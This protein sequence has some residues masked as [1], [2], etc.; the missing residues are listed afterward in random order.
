MKTNTSLLGGFGLALVGTTCCALPILLV[1][2]G[3]GSAVASLVSTLPWLVTL[4]KYK[5]VTFT[6]TALILAYSFLRLRN[7]DSCEIVDQRRLKRQRALLWASTVIVIVSVFT[8]YAL[9][10]FTLWLESTL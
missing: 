6:I 7:M 5:A 9:L 1:T 2:L 10:P 4:S 8:A 3:M